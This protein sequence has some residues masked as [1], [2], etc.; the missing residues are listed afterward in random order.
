MTLPRKPVQMI[1]LYAAD[2][3]LLEIRR[4]I[5]KR[6]VHCEAKSLSTGGELVAELQR[7]DQSYSL[8]FICHSVPDGAQSAARYLARQKRIAVYELKRLSPPEE[9]TAEVCKILH[10]VAR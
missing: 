5:L 3:T 10:L 6:L 4:L 8:L 2:P 7:N 9:W 1:L